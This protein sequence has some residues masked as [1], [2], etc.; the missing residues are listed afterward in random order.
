MTH[1]KRYILFLFLTMA[2]FGQANT[3][4]QQQHADENKTKKIEIASPGADGFPVLIS[5]TIPLTVNT[6]HPHSKTRKVTYSCY[7][8][9][10]KLCSDRQLKQMTDWSW[11]D[12]IHLPQRPVGKTIRIKAT[13]L[14]ANGEKM[15]KE[16]SFTYRKRANLVDLRDNWDNLAG[17]AAHTGASPVVLR[18]PLQMAWTVNIGANIEKASP[19]IY[20][21]KIYV[22]SVDEARK[23]KSYIYS[24]YSQ[25]GELHWKYP[26][27]NSIKNSIVVE[28]S[29]VYAQTI[30]GSLYAIKT[31]DGSLKWGTQLHVNEKSF[32]TEGLAIAD[33]VVYA[34]TGLG[35]CA[36]T[37]RKGEVL[38]ENKEWQQG[39][40]TAGTLTVGHNR[41]ISTAQGLG[42]YANDAT[43]GEMKWHIHKNGIDNHA[44]TPAMH[45][46]LL[47]ATADH[48]LFIIDARTGN[49]IV[50]K[51]YPFDL[52]VSS[53]PLLTDN[54]IVFG[55]A[56]SGLIA[57][58]RET[59]E[60][61]WQF[62]VP[63]PIETTPILSG[64]TIYFGASDGNLYGVD[65]ENGL[66][67][68]KH[69]TGAPVLASVAL[70]GNALIAVDYGGN[71]YAFTQE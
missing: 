22:A 49:V 3:M 63:Q 28:D 15:E 32:L 56:D 55:S 66:Q 31:V 16:I 44:A 36:L 65:K 25:T 62:A 71:I 50:R 4:S 9:G 67:L 47:Y 17:N 64:N 61:K 13:A 45:D 39:D 1:M 59:L 48:S 69:Q 24:L 58:D 40:A 41:V 29:A 20:K 27:N 43:T 35:L 68:W 42:M 19:V 8:D 70:S 37:A 30:E 7:I 57:V 10:K 46:G 33:S 14:F 26:V 38:W 53:T 60:L 21:G 23:G 51:T 34:G 2:L 5:G 18:P 52:T 11:R 6:H 12:V 54:A